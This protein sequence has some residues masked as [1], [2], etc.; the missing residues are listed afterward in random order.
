MRVFCPTGELRGTEVRNSSIPVAIGFAGD[1]SCKLGRE[2]LRCFANLVMRNHVQ[3]TLVDTEAVIGQKVELPYISSGRP[4][5][6]RGA[7]FH[8]YDR[9]AKTLAD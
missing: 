1:N 3:A 8:G 6:S 2:A 5:S 7:G 4:R 9:G